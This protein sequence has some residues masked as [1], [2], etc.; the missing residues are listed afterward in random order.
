MPCPVSISTE[1]SG[2]FRESWLHVPVVAEPAP[3][4]TSPAQVDRL[5][6]VRRYRTGFAMD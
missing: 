2:A 1:A 3:V 6:L 5:R 4:N